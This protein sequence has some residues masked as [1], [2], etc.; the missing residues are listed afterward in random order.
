MTLGRRTVVLCTTVAGDTQ[1][2]PQAFQVDTADSAWESKLETWLKEHTS[3]PAQKPAHADKQ[4]R[5]SLPD[6]SATATATRADA[7]IP[8]VPPPSARSSYAP[9]SLFPA[10]G[11]RDRD[12]VLPGPLGSPSAGVDGM[13]VGPDHPLLQQGPGRVPHARF[14]P[15]A[16]FGPL[17]PLGPQGPLGGPLG[18]GRGGG[19]T[20][21]PDFDDMLPPQ[22][23]SHMF[24]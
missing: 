3:T 10:I 24:S 19:P 13:L 2:P 1:T 6:T 15:V 11:N 5:T 9:P 18:P 23:Y 17:G 7:T 20:G 8:H 12:P 22:P 16:P 4:Q 21:D 14:D